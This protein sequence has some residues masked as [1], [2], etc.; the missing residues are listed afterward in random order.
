MLLSSISGLRAPL[1][2]RSTYQPQLGAR[3]RIRDGQD[4]YTL[5]VN[6]RQALGDVTLP[7]EL[8]VPVE[9]YVPGGLKFQPK[10]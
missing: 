10:G 7:S 2:L 8:F 3:E 5:R 4:L 9:M 1:K 6:P